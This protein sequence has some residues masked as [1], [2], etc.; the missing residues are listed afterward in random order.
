[1]AIT[2]IDQQALRPGEP[3]GPVMSQSF[4]GVMFDILQ[5]MLRSPDAAELRN[6]WIAHGPTAM[7]DGI[8]A[9]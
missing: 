1:M 5:R 7:L 2:A 3:T 8:A 9:R 4:V 6:R